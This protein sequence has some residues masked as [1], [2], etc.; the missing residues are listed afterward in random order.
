MNLDLNNEKISIGINCFA[1]TNIQK[2][3]IHLTSLLVMPDLSKLNTSNISRMLKFLKEKYEYLDDVKLNDEK[4]VFN[5]YT[6]ITTYEEIQN[7]KIEFKSINDCISFYLKHNFRKINLDNSKIHVAFYC[8]STSG[9]KYSGLQDFKNRFDIQQFNELFKDYIIKP[10]E[11]LKFNKLLYFIYSQNSYLF[12]EIN[13]KIN[14]LYNEGHDIFKRYVNYNDYKN[15]INTRIKFNELVMN[16]KRINFVNQFQFNLNE[17][18]LKDE[19]DKYSDI[20]KLLVLDKANKLD[21]VQFKYIYNNYFENVDFSKRIHEILKNKY[22]NGFKIDYYIFIELYELQPELFN[23]KIEKYFDN[24]EIKN[25]NQKQIENK[26]ENKLNQ[27]NENELNQKQIE[28]KNEN[29]LNQKQIEIKNENEL[30]QLNENLKF[31]NYNPNIIKVKNIYNEFHKL[32]PNSSFQGTKYHTNVM[33]NRNQYLKDF[34]E[35]FKFVSDDDDFTCGLEHYYSIYQEYQKLNLNSNQTQYEIDKPIYQK[36]F[37]LLNI[38]INCPDKLNNEFRK[39]IRNI[40]TIENIANNMYVRYLYIIYM[41]LCLLETRFI[42][43]SSKTNKYTLRSKCYSE[44]NKIICP[45]LPFNFIPVQEAAAEDC[46]FSLIH[47]SNVS[48]F[49]LN[50]NFDTYYYFVSAA[51]DYTNLANNKFYNI[52]RFLAYKFVLG[53][54]L[55]RYTVLNIGRYYY[56]YDSIIEFEVLDFEHS[57]NKNENSRNEHS[58]SENLNQN[59]IKINNFRFTTDRNDRKIDISNILNN[60]ENIDKWNDKLSHEYLGILY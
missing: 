6:I 60:Y 47:Y 58:K 27:L 8:D 22:P 57:R 1:G 52:E 29:K 48:S 51:N 36:I 12:P 39:N 25:E 53:S 16:L 5:A 56:K 32:Y 33:I 40:F 49:I 24:F 59:E 46:A 45:Y 41:K 19:F 38:N 3:I 35:Y 34:D 50:N 23:E 43:K 30:N 54:N 13:K 4:Y 11:Y 2:F 55:E 20:I 18:L 17:I 42:Y 14:D 28:N 26:N 9:Y 44:C 37:K 21:I 31:K 10:E 15:N 7:S